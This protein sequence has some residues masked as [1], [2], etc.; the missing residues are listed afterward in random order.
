MNLFIEIENGLTK[1]HP[2]YEENL[3]QAFGAVPEHWEPFVRV[4]R[5]TLDT[6]EILDPAEATYAKVNGV[7]TDVWT[8]RQMNT[9]E[10]ATKLETVRNF[11]LSIFNAKPQAEN[12]SA[13]VFDEETLNMVPPIP[14][15]EPDQAKLDAGI[16]TFWCGAENGWRDSPPRP[17]D[18]NKYKFDFIEWH[19]F[20]VTE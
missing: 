17:V 14:R 3:I 8:V 6:Y 19:W 5:P 12:W 13:W 16:M 15:P 4:E 2:A 9:E 20:Q 18:G 1:N 7:W 11:I 10:R